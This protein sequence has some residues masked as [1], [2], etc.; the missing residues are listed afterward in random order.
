M[1]G[2][3]ACDSGP[4]RKR[5][6]HAEADGELSPCAQ[7]QL[8]AGG[9]GGD[10]GARRRQHI[11]D[12]CQSLLA[13]F[14]TV[15]TRI[16]DGLLERFRRDRRPASGRHC[17]GRLKWM[18]LRQASK[19]P[20]QH[21][22]AKP[23]RPGVQCRMRRRLPR[24]RRPGRSAKAVVCFDVSRRQRRDHREAVP[25]VR[26]HVGRQ[27]P[28]PPLAPAAPSQR[29][30]QRQ[31]QRC[32]LA[33]VIVDQQHRRSQDTRPRHD[34]RNPTQPRGHRAVEGRPFSSVVS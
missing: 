22:G 12:G 34:Q 1:F 9:D 11:G 13:C 24:V 20:T 27:H 4:E 23:F 7:R 31:L 3:R 33:A 19:R 8:V 15:P 21:V 18:R 28:E 25:L 2:R 5:R 17:H 6:R 26:Q 14:R 29:N 16:D 30:A 10:D 32:R